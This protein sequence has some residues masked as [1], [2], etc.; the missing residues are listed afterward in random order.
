MIRVKPFRTKRD[1]WMNIGT[2][3]FM[4][5]VHIV[6]FVVAGDDITLKLTDTQRK[7]VGWALIALCCAMVGYNVIFI[8]VQQVLALWSFGQIVIHTLCK[9][10]KEKAPNNNNGARSTS[11]RTVVTRPKRAESLRRKMSITHRDDL[12]SSPRRELS[13]SSRELDSTSSMVTFNNNFVT[14]S[15]PRPTNIKRNY[16]LK[17]PY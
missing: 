6:I 4:M 10:K 17:T 8:F 15:I 2:E 5:M 13:K 14:E 9:K 11:K 7:N 16:T 3:V 12:R 1:A